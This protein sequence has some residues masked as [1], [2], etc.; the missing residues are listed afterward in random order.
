MHG[1]GIVGAEKEYSWFEALGYYKIDRACYCCV[2]PQTRR[3]R[4]SCFRVEAMH[5]AR[6][7]ATIRVCV[8]MAPRLLKNSLELLE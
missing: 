8:S 4:H 3:R 1:W 5:S 2:L 7:D 6:G